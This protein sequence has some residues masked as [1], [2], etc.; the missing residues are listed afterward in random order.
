MF[1]EANLNQILDEEP[2]GLSNC[3]PL[4]K[5]S[6]FSRAERMRHKVNINIVYGVSIPINI[7]HDLR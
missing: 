5:R 2:A 6:Q 1:V 7:K 4:W 3:E